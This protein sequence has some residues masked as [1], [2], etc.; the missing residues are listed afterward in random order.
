MQ[1]P[2]DMWVIIF[3]DLFFCSLNFWEIHFLDIISLR[4]APNH[5]ITSTLTKQSV[6]PRVGSPSKIRSFLPGSERKVGQNRQYFPFEARSVDCALCYHLYCH[7]KAL[8]S[9]VLGCKKTLPVW[10]MRAPKEWFQVLTLVYSKKFSLFG[11]TASRRDLF[12]ITCDVF[13]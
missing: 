9:A 2:V 5:L 1:H 3:A 7:L 8:C 4:N 13:Q 12:L 11:Q 10:I 6:L